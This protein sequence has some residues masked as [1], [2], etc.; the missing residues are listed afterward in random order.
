[1]RTNKSISPENTEKCT[2]PRDKKISDLSHV[3]ERQRKTIKSLLENQSSDKDV[4]RNQT[5]LSKV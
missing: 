2:T 5:Y 3:L 1:M 4:K